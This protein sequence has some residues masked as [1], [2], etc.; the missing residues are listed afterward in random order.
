MGHDISHALRQ[1]AQAM[2]IELMYI[3]SQA[4]QHNECGYI[5]TN[6]LIVRLVGFRQE[7][8]LRLIKQ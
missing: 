7:N 6:D 8:Y 2:D 4:S 5:I 3:Q 1:W